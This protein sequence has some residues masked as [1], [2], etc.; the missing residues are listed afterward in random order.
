MP[1]VSEKLETV[2]KALIG[3]SGVPVTPYGT[4]GSIDVAKL[5]ALIRAT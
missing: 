5:D 1:K 2:R 3:I 4:D